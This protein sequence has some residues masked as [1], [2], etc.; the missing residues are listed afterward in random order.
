GGGVRGRSDR[1]GLQ[2][3][4]ARGANVASRG[5]GGA[6]IVLPQSSRSKLDLLANR[7]PPLPGFGVRSER[8]RMAE[9]VKLTTAIGARSWRQGLEAVQGEARQF[10]LSFVDVS[11]IH[12]AFAPMAREQTFDVCEMAIVTALQAIAYGKPLL[13]L[14]VAM[15]ARF[16]QGCLIA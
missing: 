13:L 9:R 11:P 5:G 15:A 12:R 16:Q 6:R 10:A 3:S 2:L 14:P 4:R 7:M 1:V 8:K